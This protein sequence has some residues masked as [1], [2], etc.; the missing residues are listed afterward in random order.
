MNHW[1][2]R[3]VGTP[4]TPRHNCAWLVRRVL[5][6]VFGRKIHL[7]RATD[8]RKATLAEVEALAAE[9]ADLVAAPQDGDGVLMRVC[10]SLNRQGGHVG[11]YTTWNRQPWVLHTVEDMGCLFQPVANLSRLQLEVMG[12]YRWH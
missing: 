4:W 12:W 3:Y 9:A 10:G 2:E 8:W 5:L 1:A 11:V 6:E 7:P